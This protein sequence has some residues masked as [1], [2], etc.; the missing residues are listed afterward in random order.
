MSNDN[1]NITPDYDPKN[2]RRDKERLDFL[3]D[4]IAE[5]PEGIEK[6]NQWYKNQRSQDEYPEIWLQEADLSKVHLEGADLWEAHLE[7]AKLEATHLEGTKLSRAYLQG[8][9]LWTAH[10]EGTNLWEAHLEG[11]IFEA[12]YL[13]GAYLSRAHLEGARLWEVHLE[14]AD[15]SR[16][17]LE[18]A[19]LIHNNLKGAD[20]S[21][22]IVDGGTLVWACDV[23]L[24]TKF[25]AVGLDS[26]R[27]SPSTK[28]LLEYNI[29][30]MN[31]ETWYEYK[32]WDKIKP[33]NRRKRL[34]RILR[35]PVQWFGQ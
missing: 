34:S 5:G 31:W 26:I 29:R 30:R 12:T 24:N 23:D 27:I 13:E 9:N 7:V 32:D 28:Q 8:A 1:K 25:E 20:F 4:F 33:E 18:G 11:A 35:Q 2:P 19:R 15:L 16:A 6:W 3:R 17:H 21:R 10:L 14:G 22:A